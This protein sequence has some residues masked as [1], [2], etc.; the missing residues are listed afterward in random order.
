MNATVRTTTTVEIQGHP[1]RHFIC[2]LE[3]GHVCAARSLVVGKRLFQLIYLGPKGTETG[4]EA[5]R[6]LDSFR[7]TQDDPA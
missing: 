1:T 2:D 6:F 5:K 7:L 4:A 3:T